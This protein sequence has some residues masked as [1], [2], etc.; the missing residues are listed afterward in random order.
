[1]IIDGIERS[2]RA[3]DVARGGTSCLCGGDSGGPL[4]AASDTVVGVACS[5]V[6]PAEAGGTDGCGVEGS[7]GVYTPVAPY[8]AWIE[9]G[10]VIHFLLF[11]L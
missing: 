7:R 4:L 10:R 5:V 8:K 6:A 1:M 3:R 11:S 9:G 2:Q